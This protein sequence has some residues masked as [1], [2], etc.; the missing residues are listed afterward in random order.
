MNWRM[1]W[2]ADPRAL[3]L[4]DAHY[5][6]QT[7]GSPQ[8]VPP[9]RCLVLLT[10]HADAYF[11]VS[12][13]YAAFVRHA[14]PGAWI[15]SAFRNEGPVLSSLLIREAVA[16]TRHHFGDPPALG[17]VTFVDPGKTRRKRDPGRCFVRAGFTRLAERTKE[18]ALV[19][20]QMLTAEMPPP[21]NQ[22]ADT[23]WACSSE[24]VTQTL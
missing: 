17:F 3:P 12:W 4:A 10:E 1:S 2:R 7:P 18:D 20:L 14:W 23:R 21:P 6:R 22:L 15:C 19:V 11:V 9:G 16:A 8:F 24:D 5:T 13:P